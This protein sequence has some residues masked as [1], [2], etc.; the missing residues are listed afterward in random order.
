[1]GATAVHAMYLANAGLRTKGKVI[2]GQKSS[3]I[4][5]ISFELTDDFILSS[6]NSIA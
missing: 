6:L 4:V 3:K 1:M 5:F 2:E